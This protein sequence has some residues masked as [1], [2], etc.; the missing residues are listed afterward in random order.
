WASHADSPHP[1]DFPTWEA[2]AW[3]RTARGT[4][5]GAPTLTG[6]PRGFEQA[7]ACR[8]RIG[9]GSVRVRAG[10]WQPGRPGSIPTRLVRM[11]GAGPVPASLGGMLRENG[12]LFTPLNFRPQ[13][14]HG[15]LV[16]YT[17]ERH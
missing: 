17:S 13:A 7:R 12:T 8:P 4:F 14:R 2:V 10:D 5:P 9:F 16:F 1:A 3:P 6:R 15:T 11:G